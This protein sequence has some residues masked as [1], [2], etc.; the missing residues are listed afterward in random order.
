MQKLRF[1]RVVSLWRP[2]VHGPIRG[3]RLGTDK[4]EIGE[5]TPTGAGAVSGVGRHFMVVHL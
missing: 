4:A 1:Q 3:Q 5:T 2:T